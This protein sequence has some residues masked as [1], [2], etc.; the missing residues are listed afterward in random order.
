MSHDS[1]IR[2][3]GGIMVGVAVALIADHLGMSRW[4][5]AGV[6]LLIGAGLPMAI[7]G[8]WRNW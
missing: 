2:G 4:E 5:V 3:L 8:K 6:A 1:G 7:S